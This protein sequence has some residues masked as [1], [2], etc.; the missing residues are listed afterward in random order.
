MKRIS[1][2]SE[3][4]LNPPRCKFYDRG[5]CARGNTCFYSHEQVPCGILGMNGSLLRQCYLS[6]DLATLS[7]LSKVCPNYSQGFCEKGF[8]CPFKHVCLGPEQ[9]CPLAFMDHRI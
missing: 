4:S 2:T 7:D 9:V 6:E 5:Y 1:Q 3:T 8:S